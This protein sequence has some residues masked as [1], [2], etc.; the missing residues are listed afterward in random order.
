LKH[1]Q[2][3][4]WRS[5]QTR[6][7]NSNSTQWPKYGGAGVSFSE[8]WQGEKGFAQFVADVGERPEGTTLGRYLDTGHYVV[9]NVSW[10]TPKEQGA[11]AK[12]KRAMM[13]YRAARGES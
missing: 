10:Q 12:G 6:C 13:A 8:I 1:G 9:G 7:M 4:T 5:M 11:E 2:R 3:Q